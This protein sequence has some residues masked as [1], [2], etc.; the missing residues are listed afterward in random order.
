M[1]SL[2][3]DYGR[4]VNLS[5]GRTGSLWE[6]RYKANLVDSSGYALACYRYIELNPV[7]AGMVSHPA[8]YPWSSFHFN[9]LGRTG[10]VLSPHPAY[11]SLA[12]EASSRAGRY[13]DWVSS[14][15]A[16]SELD[17]IRLYS[18]K[19]RAWGSAEFRAG[20]E[21]RLGWPMDILKP[22]PKPRSGETH[23]SNVTEE[24]LL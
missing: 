3:R 18:Q 10:R 16:Q 1:Q 4:F 17:A 5:L 14:G 24:L 11:E 7:R 22:G 15:I 6:G 9:A 20:L 12:I 19:Q 21:A 2:G 23:D 8:D 13:L